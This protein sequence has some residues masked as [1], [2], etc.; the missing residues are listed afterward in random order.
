MSGVS[1]MLSVNYLNT[2][3][4]HRPVTRAPRTGRMSQVRLFDN[5]PDR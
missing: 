1:R 5:S 2:P 3:F 4:D